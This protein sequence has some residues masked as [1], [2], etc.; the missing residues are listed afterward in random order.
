MVNRFEKS[1]SITEALKILQSVPGGFPPFN[2]IL[3]CGFTPLHVQTFL[4]AHLQRKLQQKRAEIAVGLYG[5]LTGT[6]ERFTCQQS[7]NNDMRVSGTEHELA[8]VIEW[9]DLDPRLG[10]RAGGSWTPSSVPDIVDNARAR[11]AGITEV[12]KKVASKSRVAA[13]LPTLP[14][15]PVF[16]TSSW[17]VGPP[18]V[19]LNQSVANCAGVLTENA[20]AVVNAERLNELSPPGTRFDLKSDLLTGLPY[21]LTHADAVAQSLAQ[22]LLPDEPKKGL[23]TDLDD[24]VWDGLVGEDGPEAV[25]WDLASH[26]WLH[27]L[28]QKLL[29]ALAEQGVLIAVATKN[30]ARMVAKA[31]ERADLLLSRDKIFPLEVHWN[32]KSSSVGRI[33]RAWNINADSV[34]FVDDSA[35]ELAEVAAAHPRIECIQFPKNDY[36]AGYHMLRRLRDLFAKERMFYEDGLRQETLRRLAEFQDALETH[37]TPQEFLQQLHA[38]VTFDYRCHA[39]DGR[40]LELVNKTNQF[41]LNGIRFSEPDWKRIV[42]HPQSMLSVVSYEDK[43]GSLGKI[44]V[45][46]GE[47]EGYR[48]NVSTW[49]MSCRALAR[50]IE[51]QSLKALFA[52]GFEEIV[53]QFYRSARNGPLQDFFAML[54]GYR[55][56]APFGLTRTAFEKKCPE[57]YHDVRIV[58]KD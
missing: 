15:P 14:L 45:L 35:A 56:D 5:D 37:P 17:Q 16:H 49:V 44:A 57:M 6:L 40:A 24:T 47:K 46:R 38:V 51:Y 58:G 53:F 28:Y 18:Q 3:V 22:L 33:L 48:L 36:A 10:Y 8:V 21:T 27:G 39:Q 55:P 23:I 42:A 13:C 54:L 11:L 26:Q 29:S 43:F 7:A 12:L 31:F 2:V 9:A 32:A 41:N 20:V 19:A 50:Q 25:S 30:D 52:S 1:L 4:A 34:V